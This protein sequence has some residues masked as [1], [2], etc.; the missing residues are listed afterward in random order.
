[1][2]EDIARKDEVAEQRKM[3]EYVIKK[4][5]TIEDQLE[6]QLDIV[7]KTHKNFDERLGALESFV[8]KT[9]KGAKKGSKRK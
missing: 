9:K 4:V 8:K 6:S 5:E 3:L 7:M 1:M 2:L